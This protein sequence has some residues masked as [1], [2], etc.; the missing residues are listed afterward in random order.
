MGSGL[1]PRAQEPGEPW[2]C[3][4]GS[5]HT[6]T[7]SPSVAQAMRATQQTVKA[8]L[9]WEQALGEGTWKGLFWKLRPLGPF[10][11][12][13]KAP[14]VYLTAGCLLGKNLGPQKHL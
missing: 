4:V 12:R 2:Q 8:N 5:A 11:S 9:R 14:E 10:L 6:D 3:P 13:S 7:P 1:E